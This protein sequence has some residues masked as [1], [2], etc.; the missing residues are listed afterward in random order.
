MNSPTELDLAHR[1][2]LRAARKAPAALAERLE[3]EWLADL[4]ARLGSASRLRLAIGCCWATMIIARDFQVPQLAA[5][6]AGAGHK[7]LFA[8]LRNDLPLLSRR[9]VTFI[10]IAGLHAL[11][12]YAFASGFVQKVATSIPDRMRGVI[13]EQVQPLPPPTVQKFNPTITMNRSVPIVEPGRFDFPPD[14]IATHDAP[15]GAPTGPETAPATRTV[16]R[17]AGGP[18]TGFPSTEDY[19]PS[20]SR[21]ASESGVSHVQV[22]VDAQGR[23]TA[24]PILA[25]SSGIRRLDE[26][27]VNLAKA[28][29]GHYR[30]T[31]E[32]GQPV[33]SCFPYRIRFELTN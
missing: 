22:C 23:L 15:V 8:E 18:G 19:Y 9:T 11:L 31:T 20:A 4:A 10:V 13:I 24:D 1:L 21:R 3:E 12:I 5:T 29:S 26:A 7:P 33:S 2:I 6:A 28:G 16:V 27:A 25:R 32:D 30:P 17:V 14:A